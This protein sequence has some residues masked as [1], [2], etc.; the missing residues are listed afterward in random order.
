[1]PGPAILKAMG[2]RFA[3]AVSLLCLFVLIQDRPVPSAAAASQT[4]ASATGA[5]NVTAA[6][7]INP[8][9]FLGEDIGAQ[10]NNAFA[11]CTG[12]A[13]RMQI[14]P[15][16]YVFE[17]PVVF[18][19]ACMPQIDAEGVEM[20]YRGS[21]QAITFSGLNISGGFAGPKSLRG[22]H[23][24]Y[25]GRRSRSVVGIAVGDTSGSACCGVGVRLE[26]AWI[27]NFGVDLLFGSNAWNFSATGDY[28]SANGGGKTLVLLPANASVSGESLRFVNSS[29]FSSG[30][31]LS[32]GIRIENGG[33]S[34]SWDGDNFDNVEVAFR[35][36]NNGM[37]SPYWEN[38]DAAIPDGHFFLVAGGTGALINPYFFAN[39]GWEGKGH[40]MASIEGN[41]T[42]TASL[43]KSRDASAC[44]AVYQVAGNAHF[45]LT[46]VV[47]GCSPFVAADGANTATPA[48]I[49]APIPAP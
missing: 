17:T 1:M 23:L 43:A 3:T 47:S 22:L 6:S 26:N 15:G 45:A 36:G 24:V 20:D 4:Q 13:I 46:G 10:I 32:N 11:A 25:Q 48:M 18:S 12:N 41:W 9:T 7:T 21:G 44:A 8:T 33:A 38:P 39:R 40:V 35:A 14:P 31:F 2:A 27:E 29:F 34:T 49:A 28:F 37:S 42:A 19:G 5:S 16:K 30:A